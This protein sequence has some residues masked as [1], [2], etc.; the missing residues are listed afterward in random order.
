MPNPDKQQIS[1][2]IKEFSN[3]KITLD[4][5]VSSIYDIK[6]DIQIADDYVTEVGV[7]PSVAHDAYD[8]SIISII[9]RLTNCEKD[10]KYL[11]ECRQ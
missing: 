8:A 9:I 2:L 5:C 10:I 7:K 4:Q 6:I 1:S 3:K 11:R